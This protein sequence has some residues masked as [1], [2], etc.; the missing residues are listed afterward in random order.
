M[1]KKFFYALLFSLILHITVI[2]GLYFLT[3]GLPFE[4][5]PP[6]MISVNF[7]IIPLGNSATGEQTK[8][9]KEEKKKTHPDGIKKI[10]KSKKAKGYAEGNE[11]ADEVYIHENFEEISAR[12]HNA[13]LYPMLARQRKWQGSVELSFYLT[14]SGKVIDVRVEK[15]SG[16]SLLDE[17][18]VKSVKSLTGFPASPRTI[19]VVFPIH[20][21]LKP[22]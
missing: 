2:T 22:N 5:S 3:H 13:L 12:I 20:Y 1:P 18:A 9:E 11:L 17:S 8:S 4:M 15:S 7:S 14:P 19:R 21:V 16:Y 10:N 6:A